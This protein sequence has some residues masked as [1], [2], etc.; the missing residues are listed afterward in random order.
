MV[1]TKIEAVRPPVMPKKKVAAYC[2]V[3]TDNTDQLESL[4]AQK[5][6]YESFIRRH[7]D[8][9]FVGLY[10]D[11]GISGTKAECRNGLQDMLKDCCAGKIN[12]ILTKSISRFARNTVDCL[13]IVRMLR[14]K[15]IF[16]YF[17]KEDVD[18]GN[19][20]GELILT[21][22]S[23]FAEE[24]SVSISEN[25]KWAIKKRFQNGTYKM[26]Y[27]PYGYTKG[28]HG[29]MVVDKEEA[30]IVRWI[31]ELAMNGY[32]THSIAKLL[33]ERNIP[34]KKG[35]KWCDSTVRDMLVNEKYMGDAIFQ[36][37]YTDSSFRRHNTQ[38]VSRMFHI[39]KHHEPIV[40]RKI[41][42]T[43]GNL[44]QQRAAEKGIMKGSGKY[45]ARYAFSGKI[46]CGECGG[47]FKRR[48]HDHG[49]E[50]AWVCTTHI[51]DIRKCSMKY[52]RD[53]VLKAAVATMVNKLIFGRKLILVPYLAALRHSNASDAEIQKLKAELK[54]ESEKV[55]M[56]RILFADKM[57]TPAIFQQ[58]MSSSSK[59]SD[60][61]R[62]QIELLSRSD[63]ENAAMSA[64]K[65]LKFT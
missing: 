44:I 15:N 34:T 18:T 24:E 58:D 51:D 57:I 35:G 54:K 50:I 22:L 21:L 30:E 29:E 7:S 62:R 6:H 52:I 25:E 64:E 41:F 39:R 16:I 17:E 5:K 13:E 32:S 56:M 3:S 12:Y 43:V 1:V 28:E 55:D 36:K 26:P 47:T 38:D 59:R 10:Y 46:I 19:M 33:R 4:E 8:W 2:R 42:E 61:I 20:D 65:L 9:E 14:D 11:C 40:S 63:S 37:T 45:Q 23:S 49:S 27:M 48:I 31:F 60:E 53:D